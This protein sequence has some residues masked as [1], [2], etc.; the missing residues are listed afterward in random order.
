MVTTNQTQRTYWIAAAEDDLHRQ[1]EAFLLDRRIRGLAPG[2]LRFYR[3]KL[4]LFQ[5]F[6]NEHGSEVVSRL[7]PTLIRQYLLWLSDTG[8]NP[9]GVHG[10]YRALRALLNWWEDEYEPENWRNPIR[11]VKGPKVS[12][13]PLTSWVRHT[14]LCYSLLEDACEG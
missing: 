11:K 1:V 4:A 3:Q 9:G 14:G 13:E 10:C 8:H 12:A 7:T 5:T 6:C 2:T